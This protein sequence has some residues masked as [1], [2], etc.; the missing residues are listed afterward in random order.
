MMLSPF[1][2]YLLLQKKN[3]AKVLVIYIIYGF[4]NFHLKGAK[5]YPSIYIERE[6]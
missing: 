2:K 6:R 4:S 5:T 3:I 1:V